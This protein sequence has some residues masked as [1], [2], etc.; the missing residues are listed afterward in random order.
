MS[1]VRGATASGAAGGGVAVVGAAGDGAA[2][3]GRFGVFKV[4]IAVEKNNTRD[5]PM[6]NNERSGQAV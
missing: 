6:P 3:D 1:P 5:Y 2:G 4:G